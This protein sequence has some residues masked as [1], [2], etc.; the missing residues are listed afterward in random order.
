MAT[1]HFTRRLP[2]ATPAE[3]EISSRLSSATRACFAATL[4]TNAGNRRQAG[5]GGAGAPAALAFASAEV[6]FA[7]AD[8]FL[9][10]SSRPRRTFLNVSLATTKYQSPKRRFKS[11]TSWRPFSNSALYCVEFALVFGFDPLALCDGV[12][13]LGGFLFRGFG[14]RGSGFAASG[15]VASGSLASGLVVS[16]S[17]LFG[18]R[19]VRPLAEAS[20]PDRGLRLVSVASLR[21]SPRGVGGGVRARAFSPRLR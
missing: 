6:D 15:F 4:L 20:S 16:D 3:S 5:Q 9:T 17:G 7:F 10:T 14:F 8:F 11:F 19:R 2:A 12:F 21:A 1:N 18:V 13:V